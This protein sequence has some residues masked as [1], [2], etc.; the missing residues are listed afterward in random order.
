[1]QSDINYAKIKPERAAH[2]YIPLPGAFTPMSKQVV[3]FLT[4]I[5]F[6]VLLSDALIG[7]ASSSIKVDKVDALG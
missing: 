3:T 4:R 1:M 7:L 5:W 6:P 2:S